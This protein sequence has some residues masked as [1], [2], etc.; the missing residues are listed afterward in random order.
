VGMHEGLTA[1]LE[2]A[3]VRELDHCYEYE[4]IVRFKSRLRP[5]VF[6]LVDGSQLFGR[7]VSVGRRIEISRAL[8]LKRPWIDV[9]AV[10]QHEMA[11]QY[12]DEVLGAGHETA[13]GE[14]F[15]QVCAERGIDAKAGGLLDTGGVDQEGDRVLERIRKLLALAGSDNQNEAELA[16]RKAHQLMLKHNVEAAAGERRYC[17]R[18]IG[19]LEKRSNRLE[20]A[21][22]GI[23][24]E[25]FFVKVIII[26]VFL[27]LL[28]RRGKAY[29]ISGTRANVDMAEHVYSFLLA[30]ALRLWDQNRAD[31]RVRNGRDKLAYTSGVILGFREKLVA[32]R[33]ELKGEG[34]V[35]VGDADLDAHYHARHRRISTRRTTTRNNAAH[36]AGREA[37]RSVVLH[38]PMSSSG[39]S[40]ETR[41][42]R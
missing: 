28:G 36:A 7:W 1:E 38:K 35:W 2:A 12:V 39:A 18:Q 11:H 24:A 14:T 30:T 25:F 6:A 9:I 21:I 22:L 42:L 33:R 4:N 34:L 10:L 8:I 31:H 13:H 17:V 3:L 37:G 32:E 27:P 29:E 16:M 5:A 26:P 40:G 41:L 23:L 15:Q 19:D 20:S